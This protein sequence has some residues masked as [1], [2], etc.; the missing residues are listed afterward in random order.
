MGRITG[1]GDY[2][3]ELLEMEAGKGNF[4]GNV[5]IYERHTECEDA[6]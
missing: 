3:G 1:R 2:E 6:F 4:P 5:E